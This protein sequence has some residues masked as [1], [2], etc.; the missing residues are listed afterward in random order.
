MPYIS[1]AMT[2]EG[3]KPK[4]EPPAEGL[5]PAM[6]QYIEQK[7]AAPDALLLFRMGDFYETFY[8]DA[9]TA[10]RV[11]GITLTTRGKD[12]N[13]QAVPLAGIPYHALEGYLT[14]LVKAG[15]K[16]AIS[17]QLEDP[18]LAKG[19]VKRDIVRI[20]TPGT[21]TDDALLERKADNYLVCLHH[22]RD[23]TGLACVELS[24]GAFWVQTVAAKEILNELV[25]LSPAELLLAEVAI[26]VRDPLAHV[27]KELTG[28]N[29]I[30]PSLLVTRR[31]AHVFDPYQADQRL[32]RHFGVATLEGFGFDRIDASLSAAAA[33]IDYLSETQKGS[34]NHIVKLTRR[35]TNDFVLIDQA[36][37]RSL[38][39]ERTIRGGSTS[40]SLLAAVDRTSTPMGARC[41]RRWLAAPLRDAGR[42]RE[43]QRAIADLLTDRHLLQTLRTEMGRL[44][45]I[46]RIT[47]R[48]GVGRA[49]PRD[50]LA[51][52][53]TL[54]GVERIAATL[55]RL[56]AQ[57]SITGDR[58]CAFLAE[59]RDALRGE[60]DLAEFL[61]TALRPN[62]PQVL[63]EGG[64][65]ADGYDAELDRLRTMSS[66]AQQWLADYQ[67]R[68]IQRTGIS[69]LKVGY[70]QVFGYYIEIT[71]AHASRIPPDYVRKQTLK[72]A[73]R[74][75]TDE[76]KQYE[77]EI[78][79]ARDRA[80]AREQELFEVI[81]RRAVERIAPL[82]QLA[83]AISE[84]DVVAGLAHLADERRYVCPE[85]VEGNALEIC[86][87]RHPVLEQT[88]AEKFV[89][90]DCRLGAV[91][92]QQSAV[93][94]RRS[95]VSQT[96]C[97]T[98]GQQSAV[99]QTD[100]AAIRPDSVG[101]FGP[102]ADLKSEISDRQSD[103]SDLKSQISNS[104]SE[105][106]AILTG[107]NMAGKSTYIR[108]IALLTI[109]AQTGSYVPAA[110]MRFTP[111]DRIFARIG[112][113]DE[114]TRGQSTFMV[115]MT[116][117]AN[118]LNNAS[119]ASLVI[120]DELGRG[121]STFDGLALAWAIAEQLVVGVGCRTLFATHYHE[122]TEL[123]KYMNGAVNYN[124]AVREWQ[125]EVVF[126]HRIVRGKTDRSYGVH[127]AKLAGVGP[128]VIARS[129]EILAEL[130]ANFSAT[131]RAPRRTARRNRRDDQLLL[132][133]DPADEVIKE[134]RQLDPHKLTPIDALQAIEKWRKR[135]EE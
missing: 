120:I 53:Q 54:L 127:V 40:G 41:L 69:S 60:H 31:P 134:I 59:R 126:L 6:R 27:V 105:T 102:Q 118:I 108:Q 70:N 91:S 94:G 2:R 38:E 22:R 82:Q 131:R 107:P 117:A 50:L 62:P 19:V 84:I 104:K 93:S 29:P 48:L 32:R 21:L 89:P 61:T 111:A 12:R 132:F 99:S 114:L 42:I 112:A 15:F 103:I 34:L 98:S 77:T 68:E 133:A 26:D 13:G 72:N 86:E 65:I 7:A 76:L 67:A 78:L 71:H 43:R 124:V 45:D 58:L 115:E 130:E 106:L 46:E 49:S 92:D 79:T 74:Y 16:V 36:T 25:R 80:I 10:A 1:A 88:L 90:N 135:L 66:N 128:E 83:A 75:I 55:D 81:R 30:I 11:L 100:S 33:I 28:P 109:L 116:E 95:A 56:A 4:C 123:E 121:T 24:T 64:I 87:G 5:T 39:I 57:T 97:A 52:G 23:E 122:L 63:N 9:I 125:D 101:L 110:S 85:M 73:E 20:V 14:K 3:T 119:E 8:D 35:E 18:K 44:A 47:A 17:E 51:L 37:W 129:R 113:S 96:D